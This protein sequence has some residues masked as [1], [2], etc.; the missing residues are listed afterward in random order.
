[1]WENCMNSQWECINSLKDNDKNHYDIAVLGGWSGAFASAIN[2]ANRWKNIVVIE[3]RK[4]IWWTCLNRWCVPSKHLLRASEIYSLWK[5]QPFIWFELNNSSL[6]YKKLIDNKSDLLDFFRK[7]KYEDIIETFPNISLIKWYWKFLDNKTIEIWKEKVT[8]DYW[9]IA[10]GGEPS[11]PDYK[12]INEIEYLDSTSALELD[13]L[14]SSLLVVWARAVWLEL[15][16]LFHNF[17]VKTTIFQRSSH[18]IPN[19]DTE[20]SIELE[21]SLKED[22]MDIRTWINILEFQKYHNEIKVIYEENN[23]KKEIIVEKVL[24]WTGKKPNTSNI[25]LENLN[26]K[27]TKKWNIIV[28]KYMKTPENNIYAIWDVVWNSELVTVSAAEWNNIIDNMFDN[29]KKFIDYSIVPSSIFTSP[30]AWQIWLWEKEAIDLWYEVDTRVLPY[31]KVPK[32]WAVLDTRWA[33]KMI[34]DKKTKV[35]LGLQLVWESGAESIQLWIFIIK[36]KM[37]YIEVAES[38]FVYPTFSESIKMVAQT[39]TKD[40]SKLSC[41]A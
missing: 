24:F 21:K 16:Q 28:D 26:I 25:G 10:T 13:T 19:F 17:W 3:W 40:I 4:N 32:A 22:D 7:Q 5:K 27:T 29:T 8:F 38:I 35:I 14:P 37:T 18:I 31:S 34:A 1:M 15:W 20:I 11:I 6:D 2:A 41:C 30:N 12:W 36:N 39:F 23:E 9:V 33:I